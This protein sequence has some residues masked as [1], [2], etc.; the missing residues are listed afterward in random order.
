MQLTLT[1]Q[2]GCGAAS[3]GRE[4]YV[5]DGAGF[6]RCDMVAAAEPADEPFYRPLGVLRAE[7]DGDRDAAGL[8]LEVVVATDRPDMSVSLFVR[9]V[10]AGEETVLEQESGEDEAAT[11]EL[12]LDEGEHAVR[13]VCYWAPA[14]LYPSSITERYFVDTDAPACELLEP[15][16]RVLT[17]EDEDAGADGT[18]F[19]LRGRATGDDVVL[20]PA[21][22]VVDGTELPAGPLDEDGE[23]TATGTVFN[24]LPP[25][26]QVLTF[27]ARDRAGNTCEDTATY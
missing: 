16:D 26:D 8:Q 25:Q 18:Q 2:N 4:I 27:R 17:A 15:S 12:T 3:T 24:E 22:F 23:A 11:F 20:E 5:W 13:A 21:S 6:P 19:T 7:H 1:I 14:D 10:A 9:D